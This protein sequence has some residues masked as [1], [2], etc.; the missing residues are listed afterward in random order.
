[1]SKAS[2][3]VG[4]DSKGDLLDDWGK[5]KD[6]QSALTKGTDAAKATAGSAVSKAGV[7]LKALL[8]KSSKKDKIAKDGDAKDLVDQTEEPKKQESQRDSAIAVA[9]EQDNNN[10]ESRIG[11]DKAFEITPLTKLS[12]LNLDGGINRVRLVETTPLVQLRN[13]AGVRSVT[14]ADFRI[15]LP[16]GATVD[17]DVSAATTLRDILVTI[18]TADFFLGASI[19]AAGTGIDVHYPSLDTPLNPL[20][21][22]V[23]PLQ[24]TPLNL[25]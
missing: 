22:L 10:T 18:S 1:M 14:G 23:A 20:L 17:V 8:K 24:V 15:A 19:N 21:L 7:K 9:Y 12:R 2:S 11:T 4:T 5:A 6:K 13:G 25:G 16:T 3:G